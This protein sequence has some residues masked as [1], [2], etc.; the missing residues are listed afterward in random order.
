[1]SQRKSHWSGIIFVCFSLGN[2]IL[3]LFP[4]FYNTVVSI[5]G[6][7]MLSLFPLSYI[8]MMLPLLCLLG[9]IRLSEDFLPRVASGVAMVSLQ[10]LVNIAGVFS[11]LAVCCSIFALV[12]SPSLNFEIFYH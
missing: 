4:F 10:L 7:P 3:F 1:M 5:T 2:L 9:I 6:L 12:M 8:G 11:G